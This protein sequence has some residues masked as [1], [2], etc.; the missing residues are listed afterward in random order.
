MERGERELLPTRR[1]GYNQKVRL[2][3]QVF[4]IRTGEYPDG[5][6]GEVFLDCSKAG[7][8]IRA[9]INA[10]AISLSLGLQYGVPLDKFVEIFK[11]FKFTPC[12]SISGDPRIPE[13]DSI[14]DY[15][16]RELEMTYLSDESKTLLS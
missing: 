14:L 6:L 11:E 13:A 5:R 16:V 7:S 4:H 9:M 15:L 2:G 1:A 12:G 10:V 3:G 8:S